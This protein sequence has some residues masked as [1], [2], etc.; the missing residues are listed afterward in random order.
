MRINKWS[1]DFHFHKVKNPLQL[2]SDQNILVQAK[3]VRD[4][5]FVMK[6]KAFSILMSRRSLILQATSVKS[7]RNFGW[8]SKPKTKTKRVKQAI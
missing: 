1:I 8:N 7:W 2:I 3:K 5:I 6:S 4:Q